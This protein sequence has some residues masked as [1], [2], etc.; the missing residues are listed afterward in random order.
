MFQVGSE[1]SPNVQ[2]DYINVS[3]SLIDRIIAEALDK[4][5]TY[6][7]HMGIF[8]VSVGS[9]H[10]CHGIEFGAFAETA[11]ASCSSATSSSAFSDSASAS[12]PFSLAKR[13]QDVL[14]YCTGPVRDQWIDSVSQSE[15]S[16]E[17]RSV[18]DLAIIRSQG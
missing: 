3:T 4:L 15:V 18:G 7:P 8:R 16:H 17:A 12:L 11:T 5:E 2:A 9:L 14:S 10:G 1:V 6:L 13:R